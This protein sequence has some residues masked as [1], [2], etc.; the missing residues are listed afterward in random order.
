[1][2][3]DAPLASETGQ[4]ASPAASYTPLD[5]RYI[6]L[7]RDVGRITTAA[8]AVPLLMGALI[9]LT[10]RRWMWALPLWLAALVAM[11]WFFHRWPA[12]EYRHRAYRLDADGIE[13]LSGVLWRRVMTVP[14]SRVQHTDVAQGP[15]E[16]RHGLGRLIVYTAGTD[17]ARVELPGLAHHD[18]LQIRDRLLPTTAGDAV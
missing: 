2:E 4:A 15:L 17:H 5:P 8:L 3:A 9:V 7:Q 11:A 13:I 6:R 14:R 16:R 1:M 12:V 18:A 10:P